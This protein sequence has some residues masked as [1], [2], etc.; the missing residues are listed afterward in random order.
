MRCSKWNGYLEG[1]HRIGRALVFGI[2]LP[3]VNECGLVLYEKGTDMVIGEFLLDESFRLGEAFSCCV[4]GLKEDTFE[5]TYVIG[6]KEIVDPFALRVRGN[7]RFGKRDPVFR[8]VFEKMTPLQPFSGPKMED[9]FM[10]RLHV[11]GFTMGEGSGLRAEG[12]TFAGVVKKLRYLKGLGVNAIELMPAY[13]FD[14]AT[15][16]SGARVRSLPVGKTNYWGYATKAYYMAPKNSYSA[17]EDVC[18]EFA[19][20]VSACHK[21][22]IAVFMEFTFDPV[23]TQERMLKILRHWRRMY[24]IDGF[25]VS[26]Q[27]LPAGVLQADPV[28]SDCM[29]ISSDLYDC[30]DDGERRMAYCNDHF[31]FVMRRAILGL[32]DAKNNLQDLWYT[33]HST[34]LRMNYGTGFGGFTLWDLYSYDRK[35]NEE[36]GEG[37]LDGP[38]INH[39]YNCGLEGT[40]KSRAVNELRMQMAKNLLTLTFLANGVPVLT[41]GD[42]MGHSAGGN[43]NPYNQDN[44]TNWISWKPTSR[45]KEL[46]S[47]IKQL[48]EVKRR[49]P[50]LSN[51]RFLTKRDVKVLGAPDFSVHGS[52]PWKRNTADQVSGFLYYGPYFGDDTLLIACN[53]EKEKAKMHLPELKEEGAWITE[54]STTK[55]MVREVEQN[56]LEIPPRCVVVLNRISG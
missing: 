36:N 10:Y 15:D 32:A 48:I 21:Q 43:N 41:A 39:S 37:N 45:S 20:M 3:H 55:E 30:M 14:E 11:R 34:F 18:A 13:E 7:H 53:F 9:L 23:I 6:G 35:H 42:E 29:M 25:H 22:G 24:A 54:L 56:V 17:S 28:L 19:M 4:F 38:S 31:A 49:H 16:A 44:E 26:D 52:E 2:T 47:F 1:V 5:Y 12:G 50:A 33:Y 40:S 51:G 27:R 46:Q 8:G